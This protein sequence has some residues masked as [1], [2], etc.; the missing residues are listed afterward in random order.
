MTRASIPLAIWSAALVLGANGAEAY[1]FKVCTNL[2]GGKVV[3]VH[4]HTVSALCHDRTP[5]ENGNW[6]EASCAL[7]S[8]ALGCLIDEVKFRTD[9]GKE[10]TWSKGVGRPGG[11]WY[12]SYD[13]SIEY[14]EGTRWP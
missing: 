3:W 14:H 12:L 6:P 1:D 9:T 5:V 8:T 10:Y 4:V 7:G 11:T 13:G 2:I